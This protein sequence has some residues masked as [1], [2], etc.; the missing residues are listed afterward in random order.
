[1]VADI[2]VSHVPVEG[3][4]SKMKEIHGA[5]RQKQL[6]SENPSVRQSERNQSDALAQA[7]T[8]SSLK[9]RFHIE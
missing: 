8:V 6:H 3:G 5:R 9:L 2:C 7:S 1:M 4:T